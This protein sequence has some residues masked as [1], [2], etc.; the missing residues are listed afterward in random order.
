[1]RL[2]HELTGH[3]FGRESFLTIGVFDGVHRGHLH[4]IADLKTES[5]RQGALA[6]VVTFRNHPLSVLKEGF[7]TRFLTDLEQRLGLLKDAGADFVVPITFDLDLSR[8]PAS[9]FIEFL[10]KYLRMRGLVIGPDFA[11]GNGR[12][13]DADS[14][15]LL[16]DQMGFSL[17]VSDPLV[18]E[19]GQTIR[20]TS[21]RGA[22]DR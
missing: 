1:M 2:H 14:L 4:I 13:G 10:Q 3:S 8:R 7:E 22:L 12:E 16:S 20:S 18:C 21:V 6:G 19:D 9:R 11:M 5:V 17:S 15:L